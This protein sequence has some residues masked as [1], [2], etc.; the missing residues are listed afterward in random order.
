MLAYVNKPE[1]PPSQGKTKILGTIY[2]SWET[3]H[4]LLVRQLEVVHLITY[5]PHGILS[6]NSHT[7][8]TP[9]TI[10]MLVLGR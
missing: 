4:V 6:S 5:L 3:I 2:S 10:E 7:I 8:F 9:S 1:N